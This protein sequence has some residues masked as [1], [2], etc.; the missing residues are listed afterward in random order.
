MFQIP[1]IIPVMEKEIIDFK[2]VLGKRIRNFRKTR[3]FTQEELGEKSGLSYK[4]IGEVE[5]GKVNVSLESLGRVADAL[6]LKL[7]DLFS[8][9]AA[10]SQKVIIKDKS[11]LSR[12]SPSDFKNIKHALK[13][14]NKVFEKA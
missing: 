10:T 13:L 14:L 5:R 7:V 2:V 3:G 4:Y 11:P 1:H 6:S 9:E 12:L 8:V